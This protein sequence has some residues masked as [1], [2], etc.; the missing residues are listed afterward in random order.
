MDKLKLY[1]WENALRDWNTGI[2]FALAP[3]I[4]EARNLI[5]KSDG[6]GL[7]DRKEAL[8]A[9]RGYTEAELLAEPKVFETPVGYAIYGGD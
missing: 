3:N 8:K 2:M 9:P 5:M 1:V 6:E 7:W 4:Q